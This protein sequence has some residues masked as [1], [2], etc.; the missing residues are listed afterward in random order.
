L[1]NGGSDYRAALLCDS[2]KNISLNHFNVLSAGKEPVIV[3]HNVN[4]AI[5]RNSVAPTGAVK[6]IQTMGNTSEVKN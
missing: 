2:V 5:I 1:T 3:L 6:F 4:G